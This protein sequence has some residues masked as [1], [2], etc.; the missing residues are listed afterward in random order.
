MRLQRFEQ[1]AHAAAGL[2]HPNICA[3]YDIGQANGAPYIVSELLQGETLREELRSG[4]LPQRKAIDYAIQIAH[5]LAAAHDH[6]IIHRDLKP[7]NI[8]ITNEG[9]AKVLDF[10]LAKFSPTASGNEANTLTGVLSEAGTVMG[11]VG[12]MSPEQVRAKPVDARSDLFSF[13]VILYEMLSGRKAFHGE[14]AAETMSAIAKDDPPD[15]TETNRSVSPALERIVRHCLEKNPAA[16]FQSARDLAFNL[17]AITG[18]SKSNVNVTLPA[19]KNAQL[20]LA[21]RGC[22]GSCCGGRRV[23]DWPLDAPP[24][25]A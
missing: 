2:N 3:V 16:R 21:G 24:G 11:T 22:A 14:S 7:D 12:Y 15:L 4:A 20:D 25:A 10:G 6:G 5:G 19:G 18:T 1:E 8:F 17:E 23:L 9:R 13:G